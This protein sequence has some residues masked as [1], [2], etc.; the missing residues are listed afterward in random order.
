MHPFLTKRINI[1]W[2]R[3]PVFILWGV[4]LVW[5]VYF[6]S[7]GPALKLCGAKASTGWKGLPRWVRMVYEP[8]QSLLPAKFN[9]IYDAYLNLWLDMEN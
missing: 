9:N 3:W 6:L 7:F 2:L 1:E 5:L 4:F 8:T